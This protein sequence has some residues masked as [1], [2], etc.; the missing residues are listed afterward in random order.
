M[1]YGA[2][3]EDFLPALCDLSFVTLRSNFANRCSKRLLSRK[4]TFGKCLQVPKKRYLTIFRLKYFLYTK[5][6]QIELM[7]VRWIL[8]RW[9]TVKTL[10]NCHENRTVVVK[11]GHVNGHS[12]KSSFTLKRLRAPSYS[13]INTAPLESFRF[14]AAHGIWGQPDKH[15]TH[16]ARVRY[17]RCLIPISNK[18]K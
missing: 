13:I 15:I 12:E 2:A 8:G 4:K 9:S 18:W 17:N 1:K 6:N 11:S 5:A 14:R 10:L 16:D 3:N 7:L